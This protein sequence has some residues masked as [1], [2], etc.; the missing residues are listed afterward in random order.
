MH[1]WSGSNP[2]L[3][4]SE[5]TPGLASRTSSIVS[6][7]AHLFGSDDGSSYAR[8]NSLNVDPCI[9]QSLARIR[10]VT[11]QHLYDGTMKLSSYAT[12]RWRII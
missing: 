6:A 3:S 5:M 10:V 1:R 9:V 12:P 8:D 11:A 7:E 4:F 2:S